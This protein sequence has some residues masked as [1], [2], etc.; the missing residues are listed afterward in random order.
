[1]T[2]SVVP[3]GHLDQLRRVVLAGYQH[4]GEYVT[5]RYGRVFGNETAATRS[6]SSISTTVPGGMAGRAYRKLRE[7][8]GDGGLLEVDA[9]K[10]IVASGCNIKKS[11]VRTAVFESLR[12]RDLLGVSQRVSAVFVTIRRPSAATAGSDDR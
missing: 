11:A 6:G 12:R 5:D 8:A 2:G 9:A 10:S 4:C 1:M 3:D 7:E